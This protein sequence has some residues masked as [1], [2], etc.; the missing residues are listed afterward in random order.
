MLSTIMI[1]FADPPSA[2]VSA[3]PSLRELVDQRGIDW[4]T[5]VSAKALEKDSA[6][7]ELLAR[8][9]NR[10]TAE[11]AMKFAATQPEQGKF[12]F[13]EADAIVAFAREHKMKIRGHTLVWHAFQPKWFKEGA[14]N[15]EEALAMMKEHIRTVVGRY[16]GVVDRWDVVNE[17]ISDKGGAWR[18]DDSKWYQMIGP[19]YI[20]ASFRFA[21]EADPE[22]LLYY[23]DYG[24]E[25]IN[26]KSDAVYELVKDLMAKGVPVHGVGLQ[27]HIENDKPIPTDQLRANIERLRDL[28]L[29][30]DITE[31]DVRIPEPVDDRKLADQADTFAETLRDYL[32]AVPPQDPAPT[33]IVWSPTDRYSWI[34]SFFKGFAAGHLFDQGLQPKPAFDAVCR[35]LGPKG[36]PDP[37]PSGKP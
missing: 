36:A 31:F 32:A 20:E 21:H 19:D 5:A 33:F 23:N 27:M 30:V 24:A 25:G 13:A 3:P 7:R 29:R 9:F 35:L 16:R 28:G 26:K 1:S 6:Y 4:G 2:P 37:S 22:A 14:W 15:R 34:P 11:N 18:K 17:A 8:H 12:V 10:V